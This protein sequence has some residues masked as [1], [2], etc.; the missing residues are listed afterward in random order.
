M[1]R[2]KEIYKVTMV[3]GAVNVVLLLFKFVAGIVGHSAAM[4]ADAVHS[5]SDFVTDVIVLVFVHIS[6]KPKDKSHDYGHGKFETLAMTVIG[7]A[8]LVVAVGIVYS[9]MTKIIDWANGTDLEAPGMLALW[10]ALLSIVLKEGVYRYSMV[11]ARELNSQAVEAN[12]W[13][14]RSD[15]LSSLGT[16]IGIGGAIFLGK[17]W[18][19]LDPIA[20]VVVGMFIVKV[21]IDLLRRGIGD[22]M[23]QSLPDAVEEEML[24]MVGAIPG[25]VEPHNLRTRRIGNHYAIE[26]H[27]RM[28]GDISLRESHDKASEVEDMLRNRYGEDTHVA[29]H[30]E[31]K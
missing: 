19:V 25:V 22:L 3:G 2:N 5:L 28:D 13:H 18:T 1:E 8:L 31:P 24:Q 9:G 4:V 11:K 16:A 10:A 27:I 6:G 29:V 7:L 23:E 20:S 14:H 12:A 17:R 21:A 15:A 30:V 26:L